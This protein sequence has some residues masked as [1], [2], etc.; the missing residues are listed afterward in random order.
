MRDERQ[1]GIH[2]GC[3]WFGNQLE[4]NIMVPFQ[5]NGLVP[6]L[7]LFRARKYNGLISFLCLAGEWNGEEMSKGGMAFA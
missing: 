1:S 3:V 5:E 2:Q 6:F 7:C 4:C